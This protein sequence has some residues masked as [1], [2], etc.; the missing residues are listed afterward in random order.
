MP[1]D[2]NRTQ[3]R[4]AGHDKEA[5]SDKPRNR[6]QGGVHPG[7][8]DI[9]RRGEAAVFED[10]ARK[11]GLK[12]PDARESFRPLIWPM[13]AFWVITVVLLCEIL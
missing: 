4:S 10:L 11:H 5:G 1:D 3:K 7:V 13:F 8:I 2:E 9:L 12:V 6:R